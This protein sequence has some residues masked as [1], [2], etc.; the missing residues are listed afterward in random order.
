MPSNSSTKFLLPVLNDAREI[1]SGHSELSTGQPGRQWGLGGLNRAVV[2]MCAAAWEA[3]IE[4]V[5][6]EAVE[7]LRPLTPPLGV[8]PALSAS[9][10]S[11][12]GRL[13][14]PNSQNVRRLI[15]ESF[16]LSDV[17]ISWSWRNCTSKSAVRLLDEF[18]KTRHHVAHGVTPR[19][20]VHNK[21]ASWLPGFV[22]RLAQRTD[23]A[24]LHHFSSA[25]GTTLP[26]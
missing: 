3:Y 4:E 13:N 14:T 15:A 25:L 20:I 23:Q 18:L 19:P 26:W 24:L 9:V 10:R 8:W 6:K 16:G 7:S 1:M 11:D 5:V 21:Y 22:E 2:V 12:A 17:T